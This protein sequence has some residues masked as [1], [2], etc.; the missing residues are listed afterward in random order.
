MLCA[1]FNSFLDGI[2][3]EDRYRI[4]IDLERHADCP[5]YATWHAGGTRREVVV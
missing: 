3:L 1:H 4:F 2:R 5:P